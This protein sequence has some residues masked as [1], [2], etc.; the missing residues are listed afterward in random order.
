MLEEALEGKEHIR[1]YLLVCSVDRCL[2]ES[3]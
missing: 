1:T 3:L 2:V